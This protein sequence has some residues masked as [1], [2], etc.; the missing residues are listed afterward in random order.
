M[1]IDY[2]LIG[3]RI[4]EERINKHLTQEEM[5]DMIDTSVSFYSRL[6]T[7]TS[8]INLKRIVQ[9]AEILDTPV[10]YFITGI[11]ENEGEYLNQDFKNILKKCTPQKQRFIYQLAELVAKYL[12]K[13]PFTKNQKWYTL[14]TVVKYVFKK[15]RNARF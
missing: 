2:K 5:S 12:W 3:K 14:G 13:L 4:K 10:G 15:N 1:A 9:I 11:K 8:Q 6:E 7:G